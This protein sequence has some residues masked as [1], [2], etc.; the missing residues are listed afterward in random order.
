MQE[1]AA[2]EAFAALAHPL[3]VRTFR[4]LIAHGSQGLPAGSTLR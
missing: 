3:R 1:E 2:V 4:L